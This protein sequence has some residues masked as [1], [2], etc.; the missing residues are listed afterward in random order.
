VADEECS[1]PTA[2]LS[3]VAPGALNLFQWRDTVDF[4]IFAT[5]LETNLEHMEKQLAI[6]R[7]TNRNFVSLID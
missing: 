2:E 3:S 7:I 5:E 4:A 6:C 1:L